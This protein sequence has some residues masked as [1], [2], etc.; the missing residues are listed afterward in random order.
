M[1][2]IYVELRE[3]G[4]GRGWARLERIPPVVIPPSK[5]ALAV[6]SLFSSSSI[7]Q[8]DINRKAAL[9]TRKEKLDALEEL[10]EH[11]VIVHGTEALTYKLNRQRRSQANREYLGTLREGI[12][13]SIL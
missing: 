13:N 5:V 2:E 7:S 1:G 8:Q 4:Y 9:Y 10:L 11:K 12:P 3:E 6:A